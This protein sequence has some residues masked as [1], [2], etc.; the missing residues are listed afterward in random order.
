[1]TLFI[2]ERPRSKLC[3][4]IVRKEGR[5]ENCSDNHPK[6]L[7]ALTSATIVHDV[8][9][10]CN[11]SDLVSSGWGT[12]G[13]YTQDVFTAAIKKVIDNAAFGVVPT[14]FSTTSGFVSYNRCSVTHCTTIGSSSLLERL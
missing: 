6:R 13:V 1:M 14:L 12:V 11:R 9:R 10:R 2:P 3:A 7:L 5:K 8:S 4:E